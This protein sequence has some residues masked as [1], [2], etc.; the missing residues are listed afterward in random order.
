MMKGPAARNGPP[1]GLEHE[2]QGGSEMDFEEPRGRKSDEL[3]LLSMM[4]FDEAVS[5]SQKSGRDARR[6][7]HDTNGCRRGLNWMAGYSTPALLADK[8]TNSTKRMELQNSVRDRVARHV[9]V[10]DGL[11]RE[12]PK[13]AYAKLLRG[14]GPY[15]PEAAYATLATFNNSAVSLPDSVGDAPYLVEL[16]SEG[17]R[18]RLE[19]FEEHMLRSEDERERVQTATPVKVYCDKRLEIGRAHV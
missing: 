17:A 7:L 14:R 12:D 4:S 8:L 18:V 13:E 2:D 16:L 9:L 10:Y 6:F 15:G 11:A 1:G 5:R 19:G 3:F